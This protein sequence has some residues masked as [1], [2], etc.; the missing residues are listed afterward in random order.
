MKRYLFYTHYAFRSFLRGGARAVFAIFCVAAGVAAIV[1]L[2]LVSGN[3]RASITGNAQR[4]NRGDVSVTAPAAGMTLQD[5]QRFAAMQRQGAFLHYTPL[6]DTIMAIRPAGNRTLVTFGAVNGVDPARYPFYD[7]ITARDPAGTPLSALL[8]GRPRA[9]VVNQAIYDRLKLY[10]GSRVELAIRAHTYRYTVAGVV[11]NTAVTIAGLNPIGLSVFAI[12]DYRTIQPAVLAEGFAANRVYIQTRDAAQAATVKKTLTASLSKLYTINTAADVERQNNDA[13]S[14]LDKFLTIM[15]LLALAIGGI[16]IVN[17]MLV[18]ARRRRKEI[19]ILKA[20]GMKGNQVII[21]FTIGTIALGIAGGAAGVVGG[22]LA[23]LAVNSVTQNIMPTTTLDWQIRLGPIVNGFL[24]AIVGTVLFGLLPV[25]RESQVKPIVALRDEDAHP[26]KSLVGRGAAALRNVGLVIA[27]ALL[28]GVLAAFFVGFGSPVTNV[29]IGLALGLGLL[30]VTAVLTELF[31]LLIAGVSKIPGMGSLTL[32]L[33]FRN[34]GRQRH[35]MASTLLALCVGILAVGSVAIM[36][37]NL[38]AQIGNAA[39]TQNS[40]NAVVFY[41]LHPTDQGKLYSVV[42]SLPGVTSREYAGVSGAAQLLTVDGRSAKALLAAAA[43]I[44]NDQQVQEASAR[45]RGLAGRDLSTTE[46]TVPIDKGRILGRQDVGTNHVMVSAAL[47]KV[48]HIRIGSTLGYRIGGQMFTFKVVAIQKPLL[49]DMSMTGVTVDT[50]YLQGINALDPRNPENY[51][52]TYLKIDSAHISQ[53]IDTLNRR[54]PGVQVLDM[55]LITNFFNEWID[56]FALFPEI[57]AALSLFAGAII[58]A[59]TVAM[60][61]MER[62]R[63][64]GIMKAVGARRRVILQE[65]LSENAVVG[66]LG[67]AA[68]TA[69]AMGATVVL[70][71]QV[72]NISAGFDWL[73]I[74]GLLT[75]GTALAMGSALITAWPASGEKPLT[76]LRYE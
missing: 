58:I 69:L 4:L 25:H 76:V 9:I 35:R 16:G 22:I 20:L 49:V 55:S 64:I 56:K 70:D 3:L 17:T 37:Q 18:A 66:F 32:S 65:L 11:P 2:Q 31:S 14:G 54:L 50:S 21:T 10:V 61:M 30:I 42:G 36:A 12:V 71:Q 74:V 73:V 26:Y 44:S 57:L 68:G 48:L 33:A 1:A 40:F 46:L 13:A 23:S 5:L 47:A 27:L 41:G 52:T 43:R 38:K 28:M 19:A 51:S 60:S 45:M 8:A 6:I 62:K 29:S 7:R 75:L 67:A 53:D 24:V 63:E 59:N 15:G 72:L 39:A 34:L